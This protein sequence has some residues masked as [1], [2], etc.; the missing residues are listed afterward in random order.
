[1]AAVEGV[2]RGMVGGLTFAFWCLAVTSR[3]RARSPGQQ[4]TRGENYLRSASWR[5][6]VAGSTNCVGAW[7]AAHSIPALLERRTFDAEWHRL[8]PAYLA[9]QE[10][11]CCASRQESPRRDAIIRDPPRRYAR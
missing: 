7:A 11:P 2:G 9:T 10:F 1:M 5:P 6:C 3:T 4:E 8:A